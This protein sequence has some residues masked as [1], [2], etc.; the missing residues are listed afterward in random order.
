MRTMRTT[1]EGALSRKFLV[2]IVIV[3][4]PHL[5]LADA[6]VTAESRDVSCTTLYFLNGIVVYDSLTDETLILETPANLTLREGFEQKVTSILSYNLVFNETVKAFTFRVAKGYVGFFVCRVEVH[7]RPMDQALALVARA[8]RDPTPATKPSSSELPEEVRKYLRDP[9]PKVL[10][11]VKPEYERWFKQVYKRSAGEADPLGIAATAAYFVYFH[12][13]EYDPSG[14]PRSIEQV[15]ESRRGDCDDM[16]RVLVE[17]LNAY[18]IPAMIASGYTYIKGLNLTQPI[19]SVTYKYVNGGPHA[20]V[21]AYV[22]GYGWIS[23]DLLASSLLESPFAFEGY[24]RETK[25][26]EELV[27]KL[28]DL[29]RS[30]NATQVFVLMSEGGF[31]ELLGEPL[32]LEKAMKLFGQMAGV[33]EVTT[34]TSE[35]EEVVATQ[36]ETWHVLAMIIVLA[37]ATAFLAVLKR[38]LVRRPS[39]QGQEKA[40]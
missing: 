8:L 2:L 29:H 15:V 37:L 14:I 40:Y 23:L 4:S 7:A 20:F 3:L 27:E 33:E 31:E 11:I 1:E 19:E 28:V 9:H 6:I 22:P 17:L 13:I 32:T 35:V 10:E 38:Y 30:I 18:G 34:P 39:P 36:P 24:G 5:V 21:M 25:V 26:E 12:Y 16:S